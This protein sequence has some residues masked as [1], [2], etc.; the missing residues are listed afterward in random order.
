MVILNSDTHLKYTDWYSSQFICTLPIQSN[1][2]PITNKSV[3][4]QSLRITVNKDCTYEM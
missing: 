1:V 4:L 3:V 2:L